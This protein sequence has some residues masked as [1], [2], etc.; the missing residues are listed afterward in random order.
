MAQ[1]TYFVPCLN[2]DR[3]VAAT[4][5]KIVQASQENSVAFEILVVDDGSQDNTADE[6]RLWIRNHPE[7][8]CTLM[9][10]PKTRGLARSFVDTAFLGKGK[11]YRLVCGDDP[12]PV[13]SMI[14]LLTQI[15]KADMI[16]PY[17]EKLPGKGMFRSFL[18]RFY[19]FL[20]NRISGY[21]IRYY[22]GCGIHLR[23]NVMRWGSYSF[24][25]GFQ[26]E[27]VTR[28]LDEGATY[29]EVPLEAYHHE[30]PRGKSAVNFGNFL[31][32]THTLLE[33]LVRRI[34]KDVF[35]KG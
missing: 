33:M 35:Q 32:V 4:I 9:Q 5:S 13:E 7:I 28:L 21:R 29:L 25:F 18:S 30:K 3:Y 16:L 2:E 12:E 15:G 27:L 31:S 1:I 20:V 11:Y 6:V 23:H 17:Y 10:N 14:K 22:N 34:R 24:G 19:T 8:S 26:A